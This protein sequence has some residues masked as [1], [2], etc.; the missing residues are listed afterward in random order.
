MPTV[1]RDTIQVRTLRIVELV[2]KGHALALKNSDD[3]LAETCRSL[4]AAV[5]PHDIK[6]DVVRINRIPHEQQI[7]AINSAIVKQGAAHG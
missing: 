3:S 4:L 6:K 1:K 2:Q 5:M 7:D